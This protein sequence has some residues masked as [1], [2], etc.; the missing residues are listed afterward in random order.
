MLS[1]S[2]LISTLLPNYFDLLDDLASVKDISS[3]EDSLFSIPR[4]LTLIDK[5]KNLTAKDIMRRDIIIAKEDDPL[6]KVANI[7]Y[8][9][10]IARLAVGRN[11]RLVGIISR[12]DIG[13]A[14]FK[15]IKDKL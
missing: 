14:F 7:C 6:L 4:D 11:G 8:K 3:L 15:L 9:Y 10:N 13:H 5:F 12:I 1:S 2:R